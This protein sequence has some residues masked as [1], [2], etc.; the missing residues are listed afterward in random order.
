MA[1]RISIPT[2]APLPATLRLDPANAA[3]LKILS[4][5]SRPALLTLVLDWLDEANAPLC[6]PYLRTPRDDEGDEQDVDPT[7]LNPPMSSLEELRELYSDMQMRKTGSKRE[8]LD[9]ILEGD[10]RRGLTLYQLSMADLQHLYDH[11]QSLT[12]NAYRIVPLKTPTPQQAEDDAP[13]KLDV[14]SLAIPRLHPSTFLHSL[15]TQVLPDVKAYCNFDRPKNMSLLVLRIFILDSPYNTNLATSAAL[16]SDKRAATG[17]AF[18]TSRTIYIGF[19]DGAP[20][21][22]ISK[23]QNIGQVTTGETRSLRALV[24]E[25]VPKALSRPKE[26]VGLEQTK[27]TTK[28][29]YELLHR[30]GSGRTN[31]AGGGWGIYADEKNKESPLDVVLPSPPLSDVGEGSEVRPRRE[32]EAR[33]RAASPATKR[34]ERRLKRARVVAQARFGETAKVKDGKGVERV[35]IVIDDAFPERAEVP[36]VDVEEDENEDSSLRQPSRG[37]AGRRSTRDAVFDRARTQD[38]DDGGG[39]DDEGHEEETW[40]PSVKLTFHGSHVFAGIRQ[41]VEAGIIDGEKMPGW[42]TG[43][44]GVTVG[45]VRHGRIRGHKGS[46]L[47][48]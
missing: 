11:P 7:D 17:M 25:G 37:A 46:G 40:R 30:K 39:E 36:E 2:N 47:Y 45:A 13:L 15:Q 9:R 42:L 48:A 10:W 6:A 24:V 18:D 33:K 28:N 8:L 20:Y 35:D 22:Y 31:S 44:E 5:L 1:P 16:G 38:D 29:L 23:S 34:E 27:L 43:E 3:V 32:V 21:V 12:W 41:L 14:E 26:R 19:P 4:R